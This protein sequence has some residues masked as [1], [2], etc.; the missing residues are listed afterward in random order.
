MTPTSRLS[1]GRGDIPKADGN[2]LDALLLN[3]RRIVHAFAS[4][5][6]PIA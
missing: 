2:V 3:L 5:A 4:A 6:V 1:S